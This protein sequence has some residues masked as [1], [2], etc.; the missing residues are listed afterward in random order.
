MSA[1][2]NPAAVVLGLAAALVLSAS[3]TAQTPTQ[4]S[5]TVPGTAVTP[6]FS[7][8]GI[9]IHAFSGPS[10]E[11]PGGRAFLV[12]TSPGPGGIAVGSS[13]VDNV[14]CLAVSGNHAVVVFR[15]LLFGFG[16]FV[17][18]ASDNGPPGSGLDF[19]DALPADPSRSPSDCSPLGL[20]R[21]GIL[22]SGDVSIRD[23]P[24]L[25]ATKDQCRNGA[26]K[27]YG[28]FRNQGDCVSFVVP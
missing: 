24:A 11:E 23:A 12:V 8:G 4:D 25:P 27:T 5:L 20:I 16:L 1:R 14:T 3:A 22:T 15:D 18:E 28:V 6:G 2:R 19:F 7:F 21:P 26:W 13:S 17:A 10:G 9:D